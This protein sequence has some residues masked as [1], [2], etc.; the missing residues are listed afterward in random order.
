M[1]TL[2]RPCVLVLLAHSPLCAQLGPGAG[3]P[4]AA[5][6]TADVAWLADDA[7]LG[8]RAGEAGCDASGEYIEARFRALGLAPAGSVG[9]RQ[10]F[11]VP[12]PARDGGGSE[13]WFEEAPGLARRAAGAG[14]V[15]PLFCSEN[16]EA[17][18]PLR[19]A[20]YGIRDEELGI[21]DYQGSEIAGSVVLLVRGTPPDE[22]LPAQVAG[23][24]AAEVN[25][26]ADT[27]LAAQGPNWGPWGGLFHKVM[28]A[29]G[30][31][32]AAVLIAQH[33]R[34]AGQPP[35]S[36]D[37]GQTARCGIPAA[38]LSVEA[39]EYLFPGYSRSVLAVDDGHQPNA[40]AERH[41]ERA[42]G[43]R[44]D[45]RRETGRTFNVLARIAGA[46]PGPT[47][48]VG[49]HYDHLGH[50]GTGSLAPD[51]LGQIHNGAD[52]NASGTAV[53]MELARLFVASP[54]ARGEVVF[55][56]WSGEELGLLGSE[57]WARSPT[58]ELAE[59]CA[60]INLDMVGRAGEGVLQV[61]GAGTSAVFE[62]WLAEAGP[63]AGLELRVSLSGQGL[64]G[65]DH[66]TFLKR[67]I[68]ALHLFSGVHTDYH[69]P[70]DDTER[71]EA[72]GARRV[73]LLS[74]DLLLR[75]L[76]AEELAYVEPE[77]DEAAAS[78]R[79]G[80]NVWFGSVPDYVG[81]DHGV[82]LSGTSAGS[83][84]ER[85]G[86]F[87]GDILVGMGDVELET[88]YDFVFAL[89]K[90]KPGDVVLVRYLREEE[91]HEVRVTLSSR[92]LH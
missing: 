76:A 47:V 27:A 6:L 56:L 70:S 48:I 14:N 44:T 15:A 10:E 46:A 1:S 5:R 58:V 20:G 13:I 78:A 75:S 59:V 86:L 33:P 52:D 24:A 39:A 26:H 34:E 8:R 31:G 23:G 28:T 29:R 68:P 87:Q 50:G 74:R 2:L 84:A 69:K 77:V 19:F 64:G 80:F 37:A 88:I 92:S 66:Q 83:P 42:V 65:S 91:E 60:N 57:H 49:A 53:V 90:Y 55:A 25:P 85:A 9:F 11:E 62:E 43:V 54:P 40:R 38:M 22:L 73:T 67:S 71:F 45:V 79:G 63:A 7:R 4:D 82:L 17:R 89:Q 72:E 3:D 36:F 12:L 51:Q 16:G 30:Q 81:V 21:D 41:A 18:G 32:A 61:L 35:I